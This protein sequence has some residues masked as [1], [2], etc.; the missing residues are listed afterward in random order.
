MTY[1]D[2]KEDWEDTL[3]EVMEEVLSYDFKNYEPIE[4]TKSH[5][6]EIVGERL[7]EVIDGCSDVIY[8]G[9]AEEVSKIIGKYNAFDEWD[10]TGER[11]KS[12]SQVAFAS[13]YDLLYDDIDV[14]ESCSN[15]LQEKLFENLGAEK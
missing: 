2:I 1:N 14:Y 15:F 8:T 7:W 12:W 11:F 4:I 5:F 13:I 3:L 9:N 6:I 10:L